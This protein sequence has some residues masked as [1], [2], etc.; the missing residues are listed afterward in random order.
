M[1]KAEVDADTV[2]FNTLIDAHGREGSWAEAR[3]MVKEMRER[4]VRRDT[5]TYT[6]AIAACGRAGEAAA[7]LEVGF[8]RRDQNPLRTRI[9]TYSLSPPRLGL[10]SREFVRAKITSTLAK[11]F[12]QF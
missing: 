12:V 2:S 7:A 4:G 6:S 11:V 1:A 5:V 9:R 3:R 8:G 10:G